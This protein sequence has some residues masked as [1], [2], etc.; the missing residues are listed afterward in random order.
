M[1][2]HCGYARKGMRRR[3]RSVFILSGLGFIAPGFS[4]GIPRLKPRVI[5]FFAFVSL[6]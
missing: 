6:G 3:K 5:S 1:T 2:G 4:L